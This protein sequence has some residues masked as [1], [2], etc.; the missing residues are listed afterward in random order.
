MLL[1]DHLFFEGPVT[2]QKTVE[3]LWPEAQSAD[4]AKLEKFLV[5]LR[6]TAV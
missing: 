3:L 2:F 6:R 1:C 4:I 5:L